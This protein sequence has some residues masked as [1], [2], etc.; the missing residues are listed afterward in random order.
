M[1][2]RICALLAIAAFLLPA[3]ADEQATKLLAEVKAATA[4]IQSLTATIETKRGNDTTRINVKLKRPNLMLI[5]YQTGLVTASDGKTLTTLR[6]DKQF[7][8]LN[9]PAGEVRLAAPMPLQGFF[10]P[11]RLVSPAYLPRYAG[12]A[13]VEEVE[14]EVIELVRNPDAPKT[15]AIPIVNVKMK[16]YLGADRLIQRMTSEFERKD[17]EPLKT[18]YALRDLKLNVTIDDAVFAYQLPD[19]AKP[20]VAPAPR[21]YAATLLPVGQPAPDFILP[22]NVG[23]NLGLT[24]ARKGKRAVLVNFWFY[25]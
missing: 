24:E 19:D 20:Y 10:M 15:V 22:T 2:V 18:E 4:A 25:S 9:L 17:A 13:K 3:S 11:E 7:V 12:K 16:W 1:Q 14:Y 21:D 5:E 8:K 23:P 6:S